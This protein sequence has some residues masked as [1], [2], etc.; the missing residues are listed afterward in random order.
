MGEAGVRRIAVVLALA[1]A[2]SCAPTEPPTPPPPVV[3][4]PPPPAP[5]PP[6]VDQCGAV[7]LQ[8]LVGRPRTEIPVPLVP[9]LRRVLC[10]TCPMTRDYLASR[11]TILF[12]ATT[13]LITSVSCG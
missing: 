11:Q 12:D 9:G 3:Y 7:P 6:P 2:T 1:F 8:S 5:P 13:G 10:T 4:A